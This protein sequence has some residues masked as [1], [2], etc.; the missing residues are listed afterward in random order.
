MGSQWQLHPKPGQISVAINTED[1]A[2]EQA[3][4][5]DGIEAAIA[6]EDVSARVRN[7]PVVAFG[8]IQHGHG[9][10]LAVKREPNTGNYTE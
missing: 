2:A 8:T 7:E 3:S 5:A 9:S 6:V 4:V 10:G 1:D